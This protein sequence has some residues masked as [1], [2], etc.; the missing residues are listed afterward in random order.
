NPATLRVSAMI[1]RLTAS[2]STT[3]SRFG[4]GT[5]IAYDILR[6]AMKP[7]DVI[8]DRFEIE[9]LAGSGGMGAVYRA[10]DLTTGEPAA[11]KV[12]WAHHTGE[13]E[14][15]ERFEREARVLQELEHPAIVRYVA[16][17][18][19]AEGEPYLAL[20]WLEG[21]SL[22]QRMRAKPLSIAESIAVARNVADG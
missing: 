14:A 19:T 13:P 4:G 9:R 21:Q 11:V 18:T 7:G 22:A 6:S 16:H 5:R 20:E 15:A 8:A 12:L 1:C 10:Q 3:K 17:G 2:S